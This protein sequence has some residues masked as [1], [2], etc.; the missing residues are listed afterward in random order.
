M[1]RAGGEEQVQGRGPV[2]ATMVSECMNARV[3][4]RESGPGEVSPQFVHPG[5]VPVSAGRVEVPQQDVVAIRLG[6][7]QDG[8]HVVQSSSG[9]PVHA[10]EGVEVSQLDRDGDGGIAGRVASRGTFGPRRDVVAD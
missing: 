2:T 4:D 7:C 6:L 10:R 1:V 8:L 5:T 3:Y 9:S